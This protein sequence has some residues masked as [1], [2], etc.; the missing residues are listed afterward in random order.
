ME[1]ILWIVRILGRGR[2]KIGE[3][4]DG[5]LAILV[6]CGLRLLPRNRVGC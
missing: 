4:H 6:G 5:E 3:R 2:E 1:F